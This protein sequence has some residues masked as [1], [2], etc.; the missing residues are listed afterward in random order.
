MAHGLLALLG[1]CAALKPTPPTLLQRRALRACTPT[2]STPD[3]N[4]EAGEGGEATGHPPPDPL[5]GVT[6]LT[7]Y[8]QEHW[9]ALPSP[10]PPPSTSPPRA[11]GR[12]P[13]GGERE[14]L[15]QGAPSR[16][17]SWPPHQGTEV[18]SKWLSWGPAE[19]EHPIPDTGNLAL[20]GL[21][22]CQKC[23]VILQDVLGKPQCLVPG[24]AQ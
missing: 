22:A 10:H 14:S 9:G 20:L 13:A 5:P 4:R 24:R 7:F 3:S 8:L 23:L 16:E 6:A 18:G 1:S 17:G 11:Q 19:S 2:A 21:S 12:D 15:S